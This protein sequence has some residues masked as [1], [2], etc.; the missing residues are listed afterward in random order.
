[1]AGQTGNPHQTDYCASK[2]AAYGF[3]DALALEL[4]QMNKNIKTTVICPIYINTGMFNG[5]KCSQPFNPLLNQ[6]WVA[7]RMVQGIL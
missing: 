3:M 4:K 2:F 7:D 5:V 1:M 6:L